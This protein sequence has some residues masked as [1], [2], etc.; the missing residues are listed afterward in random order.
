MGLDSTCP[1]PPPATEKSWIG[2][3]DS[4]EEIALTSGAGLSAVVAWTEAEEERQSVDAGSSVSTRV[5][6]ALVN[7][8]E[9]EL[10]KAVKCWAF[11]GN[12][13]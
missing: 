4:E 2:R 13:E 9:M 7:V 10:K 8:C 11:E 3:S 5:A 6:Q 12:F 1:P